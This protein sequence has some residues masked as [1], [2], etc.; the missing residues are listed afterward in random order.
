[1]R[2]KDSII[3]TGLGILTVLTYLQLSTCNNKD[4]TGT[5]VLY[6][7]LDSTITAR[8]FK[9]DSILATIHA[10]TVVIGQLIK[11]LDSI[12]ITINTI[13]IDHDKKILSVIS[14][15]DSEQVVFFTAWTKENF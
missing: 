1:M 13:K 12:P 5:D 11:K 8:N 14:L 7:K 3:G 9:T 4:T 2:V 6:K 10:D 15:S